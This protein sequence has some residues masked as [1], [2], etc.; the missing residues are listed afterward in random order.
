MKKH[1][2]E[3]KEVG[4][5]DECAICC[6]ALDDP[7]DRVFLECGKHAY[8]VDCISGWFATG[9]MN[10][11]MCR[12][13]STIG[14]IP[15]T[16]HDV[17]KS[18]LKISAMFSYTSLSPVIRTWI[19]ESTKKHSTLKTIEERNEHLKKVTTQTREIAAKMEAIGVNI[20]FV[21]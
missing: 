15:N 4:E 20:T 14:K 3:T 21:S 8:H 12:A 10:C 6:S 18:W 16:I 1:V 19:A 11:P 17:F 7:K 2:D 5:D 9:K 13:D